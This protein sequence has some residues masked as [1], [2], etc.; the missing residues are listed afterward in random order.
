MKTGKFS[1]WQSYFDKIGGLVLASKQTNKNSTF[2]F[3]D[4][5]G[6]PIGNIRAN[7]ESLSLDGNFAHS[8]K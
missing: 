6:Q 8:T 4:N 5:T 1:V 2:W 7:D 3:I